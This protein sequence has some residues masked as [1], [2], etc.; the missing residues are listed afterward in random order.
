MVRFK[1]C[2]IQS[3][4]EMRM[5]VRYGA[6]AVGLVTSMPS[7]PG[8]IS[9]ESA[10]AIARAVPPGVDSFLLTCRQTASAVIEQQ[11]R[12]GCSVLQLV[13]SFPVSDYRL[14]REALS[15]IRIVQVIHVQDEQSVQEARRA[16][17][18]AD[19]LLL[20]SGT[21]NAETKVLGGTGRIHNWGFSREICSS[22]NIPVY[23][24]GGLKPDNIGEA[25]TTVRP[26]ALDVCSGLRING[27]LSE[28]LLSRFA[29]TA[30]RIPS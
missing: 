20:D 7:G 25:Y 12:V 24:A 26:F 21:P 17:E 22:V 4:E 2:C 14:L 23:L 3:V 18:H 29:D 27:V 1:V 6:S 30:A 13:D 8:V 5:A 10:A 19:A 15:G 28:S 9:D 11:R 16:A